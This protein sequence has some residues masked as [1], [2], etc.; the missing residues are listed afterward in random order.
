MKHPFR[1]L[2]FPILACLSAGFLGFY[3][4]VPSI[5]LRSGEFWGLIL[6]MA[7]VFGV[8]FVLC[9]FRDW[10]GNTIRNFFVEQ[11]TGIG[12]KRGGKSSRRPGDVESVSVEFKLGRRLKI[13]LLSVG[14][15]VVLLIAVLFFSSSRMTRASDYQTM[16]PVEEGDFTHD[17]AEMPI[18]QIPVVDRDTA[19]RLGNR[20]LGQVVELVSQFNVSSYYTQINYQNKPFRV[21]PLEYAGFLKW[22]S[23]KEEGIP[24]Y[25][26]IDMATQET[27]LVELDKENAIRYSPSEYFSRDL[28]RHVRFAYPTKMFENISFE[29]DDAGHPYWVLPYYTYTIGIL[30][31]K[32]MQGI[33]LVDAATGEMTDY[34]VGSVPTWIDRVYSAEMAVTQANDWGTLTNGFWNSVF[35]QKNCVVT[36]DGYNY[37]AVDDDVWLYT[38]ITS[39]TADE[40]NIGFILINMR[41]KEAKTYM[42]NGAEEYSAMESAEGKVQEKGYVATFPILINVLDQPSYFLSLKDN[43]GLVKQY[44]FVSVAQYQIVGVG[45]TI[46]E[47]KTRYLQ[48]LG[49]E[50]TTPPPDG[51]QNA[52]VG[53]IQNVASAV[54]DGNTIYYLEIQV[55]DTTAIYTASIRIGD[56]L[57][58]LKAGDTVSFMAGDTRII[59]QIERG[60]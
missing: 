3:L 1:K 25:I 60:N 16:L 54:K 58:F 40:S 5:N 4:T 21:S 50:E 24:Y 11:L 30:G 47:A 48:M 29:V 38:G 49:L 41:T 15:V 27:D 9:N 28:M 53:I 37:I 59:T 2:V 52:Y 13:A 34:R 19:E 45:D 39:V 57:P 10:D 44:A 31:G 51:E 46:E 43:A 55:G 14:G 12:V 56:V 7:F 17:I 36:T 26:S 35:L 18:S 20:K 33:V 22:F 32:D 8:T 23:N 42:I 6:F